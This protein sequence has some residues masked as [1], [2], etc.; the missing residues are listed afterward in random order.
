[1]PSCNKLM[2]MTLLMK[3]QYNRPINSLVRMI[4]DKKIHL[5]D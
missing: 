2:D 5:Q 1:M 4:K 3:Y